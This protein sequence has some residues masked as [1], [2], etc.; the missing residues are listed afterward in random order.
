MQSIN[1]KTAMKW[2]TAEQ[3]LK[4]LG[5]RSQTLYAN[6]S[7]GRIRAKPDPADPRRRLYN[8][9][10]VARLAERRPGRRAAETVATQAIG[11]GDPVLASGISTVANERLWY[12]G[13]DAVALAETA[14]LEEVAGLLW[15]SSAVRVHADPAAAKPTPSRTPIG[16]LLSAVSERAGLDP[17][18]RGRSPAVLKSE[19]EFLFGTL[20]EASLGSVTARLD[21]P[22]HTRL[23]KAWR[24]P[25][26]QDILRRTLVLLADHELNASTFAVRVAASTGASLAA[27][28]LA[29]LA[30][31]TGPLHGGAARALSSLLEAARQVGA[32]QAVREWLHR[33]EPLPAF[34]HPLYP[35]GDPRASALMRHVKLSGMF[36]A[37]RMAAEDLTGEPPNVDFA[38]AALADA[39]ALPRQ[40]PF[41]IFAL[42]RSV[43]WIAHALE[44][45]AAGQLIRPRARYVGPALAKEFP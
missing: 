7:R 28:L 23:A 38:L 25:Q 27:C 16:R 41:V 31:L 9:N 34:G 35:G 2:L 8:G 18:S 19:A 30:T 32:H 29:G 15:Q 10:D 5:V 36:L 45:I 6:V 26:A 4:F 20:L 12:R 13:R 43:G 33:G 14:T 11:W 3:A 1:I 40:A 17:P 39:Y 42:S 22:V 24:K 44:Q 37:V 21:L